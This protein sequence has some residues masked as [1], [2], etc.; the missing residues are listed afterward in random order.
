VRAALAAAAALALA[1]CSP[2]GGPG[3]P[4]TVPESAPAGT[5]YFVGT[6]PE[7]VGASLDLLGEDPVTRVVAAALRARDG[8]PGSV[9]SVGV[10]S[11]VNDGRLGIALPRFVAVLAS[12]GAVALP[13]SSRILRPG[14][15]P[16]ARRALAALARAPERVPPGGA[17]TAYVVLEG[18]SPAAVASV[19]MVVAGKP[20]TLAARRR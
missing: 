6:G 15:G 4:G 2:A 14:D 7:G 5:G 20:I 3:P 17:A 18:P 8:R 16:A 11:V 12:G 9:A 19:R 13:P 1:G 10:A